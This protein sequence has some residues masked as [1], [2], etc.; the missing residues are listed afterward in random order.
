[1]TLPQNATAEK[2]LLGILGGHPEL[3]EEVDG[4]IFFNP[5]NRTMFNALE[6]L[7]AKSV[8]PDVLSFSHIR[9]ELEATG[10]LEEVGGENT[11]FEIFGVNLGKLSFSY[12]RG[13]LIEAAAFRSFIVCAKTS[14]EEAIRMETPLEKL[15]SNLQEHSES[16]VADDLPSIKDQVVEVLDELERDI[17]MEK[18]TC[19]LEPLDKLLKGGVHRKEMMVIAA[20]TSRG[21]SL[22]LGQASLSALQ[23]NR[24]VAFF[25]LEMP[26]QD[27]IQRFASNLSGFEMLPKCELKQIR[28]QQEM[29]GITRAVMSIGDMPLFLYDNITELD[30]ILKT[31]K[32]VKRKKGL[33][34]LVVDYI[35]RC[36]A[37]GD[38]REQAVSQIARKLKN[39]ALNNDCAVLTASQLNDDGQVRESRAIA[40]EADI[41]LHISDEK[42]DTKITVAKFRRGQSGTS[43]S[44][45]RR[46][47]LGRFDIKY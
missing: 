33:D 39:F 36:E 43:L 23:E 37:S 38:T 4:G 17:P 2:A 6:S 28:A 26:S 45:T 16:K 22:L 7:S 10:K 31:A 21:K 12:Y 29:R 27:L 9:A 18:F 1:M 24:T 3:V 44:V 35:Q 25:S 8:S 42:N 20:P 46:G 11:V 32:M 15:L 14:I 34:V 41:L 30:Q 13:L 47:E 19:G 5:V 40:H